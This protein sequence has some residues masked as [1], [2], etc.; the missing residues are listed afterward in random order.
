MPIALGNIANSTA[1]SAY[2]SVGNTAITFLS[3][4]NYSAGN[5]TANVFVVPSGNT[6]GN[7]NLVLSQIEIATLD[8]YQLYAGGEKLL[9]S[10]GDSVQANANVNNALTTVT[11]FTTI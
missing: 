4:T 5:I 1:T 3:L 6:A 2:T 9:L 10:N 7:L 8:T 11:S